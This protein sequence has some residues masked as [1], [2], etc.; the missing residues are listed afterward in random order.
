MTQPDASS[1]ELVV[2][3]QPDEVATRL[4]NNAQLRNELVH[5]ALRDQVPTPESGA[6]LEARLTERVAIAESRANSDYI[7]SVIGDLPL[8]GYSGR[9]KFD[10]H[11]ANYSATITA[12]NKYQ[13]ILLLTHVLWMPGFSTGSSDLP[14][15]VVGE[16]ESV[17]TTELLL[18]SA[19]ADPEKPG[20]QWHEILRGGGVRRGVTPGLNYQPRCAAVA[21]DTPVWQNYKDQQ[22]ARKLALMAGSS[23]LEGAR[24]INDRTEGRLVRTASRFRHAGHKDDFSDGKTVKLRMQGLASYRPQFD[25]DS[26]A[27]PEKAWYVAGLSNDLLK[28]YDVE[29]HLLG[30]ALEFLD[31]DEL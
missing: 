11:G 15:Y 16:H 8:A 5:Q 17:K 4:A 24:I 2:R 13:Q 31:S 9:S 7:F 3:P 10:E 27:D 1:H 25:Q 19:A 18:A 6:E 14:W 23:S 26:S 22:E 12:A 29:N 20:G 30:L 21:V 28:E